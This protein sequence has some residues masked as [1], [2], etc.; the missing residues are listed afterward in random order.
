[1]RLFPSFTGLERE[2]NNPASKEEFC[3]PTISSLSLPH[4]SVVSVAESGGKCIV[5]LSRTN[6]ACRNRGN[7][8]QQCFGMWETEKKER[9]TPRDGK[10]A[11]ERK[12]KWKCGEGKK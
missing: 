11:G 3:G 12:G 10:G 4:P 1:M 9:K 5:N 8:I 7:R 2:K 6:E